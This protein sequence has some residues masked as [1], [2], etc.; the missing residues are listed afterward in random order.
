MLLFCTPAEFAL[1][2]GASPG[3][4]AFRGLPRPLF[5]FP[6]RVSV[7]ILKFVDDFL[8]VALHVS[9]V[10]WHSCLHFL[11]KFCILHPI[12]GSSDMSFAE[13]VGKQLGQVA[14]NLGKALRDAFAQAD[15]VDVKVNGTGLDE[16]NATAANGTADAALS[17]KKIP[18]TTEGLIIAYVGMV[19][20][21]LV[22][23]YFGSWRSVRFQKHSKVWRIIFQV[24]LCIKF[25][26]IGA[27]T[28]YKTILTCYTYN[29]SFRLIDWFETLK[30]VRVSIT[31]RLGSGWAARTWP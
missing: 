13:N 7:K 11:I 29:G 17:G 9:L 8:C 28:F 30:I 21:A 16:G 6:W 12:R 14:E 22:P 20:M 31:G 27:F 26:C 1:K 24:L 4:W 2:M 15:I 18:A 10:L 23:I 5:Y 19:I 3:W 25:G